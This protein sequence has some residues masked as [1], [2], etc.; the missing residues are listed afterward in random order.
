MIWVETMKDPNMSSLASA[1]KQ[2]QAEEARELA[3]KLQ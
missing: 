1:A 2:Q 3:R